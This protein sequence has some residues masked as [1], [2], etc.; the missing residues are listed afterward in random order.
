ME[1]E[2]AEFKETMNNVIE[3][4]YEL[5]TSDP[6]IG[7]FFETIDLPKL[8]KHQHQFIRMALGKP[9]LYS[10][11]SMR[12]SHAHLNLTDKDFDCVAANLKKALQNK[13]SFD[14]AFINDFLGKVEGLRDDI[15]N[16]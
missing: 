9:N 15:L 5:N 6:V 1:E 12:E 3:Y 16:R 2:T 8:K 13:S 7:H 4:F 11:R 14:E 10:G